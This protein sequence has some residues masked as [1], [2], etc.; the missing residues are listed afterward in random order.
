MRASAHSTC[1]GIFQHLSKWR[2]WKIFVGYAVIL[3]QPVCLVMSCSSEHA[4][5]SMRTSLCYT[6]MVVSP[7]VLPVIISMSNKRSEERRVG[8][9]CSTGRDCEHIDEIHRTQDNIG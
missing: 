3:N 7:K 6:A 9:E 4:S 8:K 2:P 5:S 1:V